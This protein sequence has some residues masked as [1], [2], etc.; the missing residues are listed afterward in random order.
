MPNSVARALGSTLLLVIAGSN[1]GVTGGGF[2]EHGLMFHTVG[3]RQRV[4]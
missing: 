3:C 4:W 1:V 2:L